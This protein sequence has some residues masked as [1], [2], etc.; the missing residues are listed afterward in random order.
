MFSGYAWRMAFRSM[1]SGFLVKPISKLML[2]VIFLI[3]MTS[4]WIRRFSPSWIANGVRIPSTTLPPTTMLR[5]QDWILSSRLWAVAP[6]MHFHGIGEVRIFGFALLFPWLWM[7][8]DARE[9]CT[10]GTLIVP[11][12]LPAFWSLLKPLPSRYSSLV[13]DIVSLPSRS[14]LI[15]PRQVLPK[16]TVCF[17]WSEVRHAGFTCRFQVRNACF[18]CYTMPFL[19]RIYMLPFVW[20][21]GVCCQV[22]V[23]PVVINAFMTSLWAVLCCTAVSGPCVLVSSG[24]RN[25]VSFFG[26]VCWPVRHF[27]MC[28][29]H[30]SFF[31]ISRS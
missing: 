10:V 29:L 12:W 15:I 24:T 18:S 31:P 13:V 20:Q 21:Q 30:S 14:D 9:C 5:F 23:V 19:C 6:S 7:W 11:E 26:G 22:L 27:V 3:R 4:L 28:I 25:G 16:Q 2:S 17:L 8:L 1:L